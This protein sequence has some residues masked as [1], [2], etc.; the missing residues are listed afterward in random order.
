MPIGDCAWPARSRPREDV[1]VESYVEGG[2]TPIRL[3]WRL[4]AIDDGWRVLDVMVE[5][6]SLLLTYR[7][8]FATVIERSGG[9]LAGADRRAARPRRGRADPARELIAA[10]DDQ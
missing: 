6:V 1:T 4:T 2:A 5:G 7:N 3:D 10:A 8:E 9:R